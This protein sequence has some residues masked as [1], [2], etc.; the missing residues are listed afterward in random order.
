MKYVKV[1]HRDI[2]PSVLFRLVDL[3]TIQ[4]PVAPNF[5]GFSPVD[6]SDVNAI[7]QA[8]LAKMPAPTAIIVSKLSL[9]SILSIILL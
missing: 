3:K 9:M 7:S 8:V 4:E 2:V 6:S 5:Q 1:G